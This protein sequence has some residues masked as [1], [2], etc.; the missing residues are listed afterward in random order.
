[1][2]SET[3]RATLASKAVSPVE[4][5]ITSTLEY[6]VYNGNSIPDHDKTFDLANAIGA[7]LGA[8]HGLV[9][10]SL[11]ADQADVAPIELVEG[12]SRAVYD[13]TR[14]GFKKAA[15]AIRHH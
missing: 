8:F 2:S 4:E 15:P 10:G 3:V 1:M 9:T 14:P 13:V 12:L 7:Q 6:V 11:S 5:Y